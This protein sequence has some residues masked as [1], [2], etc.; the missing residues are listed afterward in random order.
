MIKGKF[1]ILVK[2][3]I[4]VRVASEIVEI[5]SNQNCK[6]VLKKDLRIADCENLL[7]IL[8]LRIAFGETVDY[9][10]NGENHESELKCIQSIEELF[11]AE[12]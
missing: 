2:L 8:G 7:E 4:H 11:N 9:E 10:V 6:M 12:K 3:G 5:L 1:N